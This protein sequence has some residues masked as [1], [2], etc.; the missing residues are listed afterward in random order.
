MRVGLFWNTWT[1][2][3]ECSATCQGGYHYRL[4]LCLPDLDV[5]CNTTLPQRG[6]VLIGK[7]E[8][9]IILY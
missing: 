3:T 5:G 8:L 4:K 6:G 7:I 2:W 1:E 9:S